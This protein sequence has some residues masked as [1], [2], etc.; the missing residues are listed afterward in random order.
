MKRK[1]LNRTEMTSTVSAYMDKNKTLW[2]ANK[3]IAATMADLNAGIG[4]VGQK[5][6]KQETPTIGEAEKKVL[7][8]HDFED[9]ILR[10]A[11]QLSA[12]AAAKPDPSLAA[13]VEFTLPQLDKLAD[14]SLEE[15]G[16]RIS[17]LATANLAALADYGITQADVTALD[18]L[19]A[20]FHGVKAAPRTAIASRS[21]QTKTMPPAVKSTT[22]ILRNRLDKQM[23]MFKKTNPEFYAGYLSARVVVARGGSGGGSPIP[24]TPPPA[25]PH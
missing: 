1:L 21:G 14:D 6:Q 18:D 24:P 2:S 16:K 19:T 13:Q 3:A 20:Q 12:L 23:L 7:T 25:P 15:T 17:G 11:G 4:G 10:I 9:E 8:R 22:S 5:V